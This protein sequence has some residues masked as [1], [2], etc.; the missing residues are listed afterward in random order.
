MIGPFMRPALPAM[1]EPNAIDPQNQPSDMGGGRSGWLDYLT[2]QGWNGQGMPYQYAQQLRAQGQ[3]PRWDYNHPGQ[4]WPGANVQGG[5]G[6]GGLAQNFPGP[7]GYYGEQ[8][9]QPNL[10]G[11][12]GSGINPGGVFSQQGFAPAYNPSAPPITPPGGLMDMA[13]KFKPGKFPQA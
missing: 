12:D 6:L 10:G 9:H 11:Y 1:G 8:P 13:R 5:Q 2:A 4:P 3:H 7:R